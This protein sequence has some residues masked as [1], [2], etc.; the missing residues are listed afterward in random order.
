MAIA[1]GYATAPDAIC[2]ILTASASTDTFCMNS[3]SN[4]G[5]VAL[6][7]DKG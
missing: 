6:R 7:S 4:E 1:G 2:D 3:E 5:C